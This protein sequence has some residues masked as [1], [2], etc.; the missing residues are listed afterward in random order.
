MNN[1]VGDTTLGKATESHRDT[2]CRLHWLALDLITT[3]H[4]DVGQ[5]EVATAAGIHGGSYVSQ[6]HTCDVEDKA[7]DSILFPQQLWT[8]GQK[9]RQAAR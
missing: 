7:F 1:V 6:P 9:L 4:V 5:V 8:Y 3:A 2:A